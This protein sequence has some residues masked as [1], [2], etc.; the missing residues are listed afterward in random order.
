MAYIALCCVEEGRWRFGLWDGLLFMAT[1]RKK[2][3]DHK[4]R[5]KTEHCGHFSFDFQHPGLN[6][7]FQVI[8]IVQDIAYNQDQEEDSLDCHLDR[9]VFPLDITH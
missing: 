7:F 3:N 1:L 4:G 8:L 9:S 2:G 5:C 6:N